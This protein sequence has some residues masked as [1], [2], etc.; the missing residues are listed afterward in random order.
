MI[1]TEHVYQLVEDIVE[2]VYK[3]VMEPSGTDCVIQ[4]TDK[5]VTW[6]EVQ[7]VVK[8]FQDKGFEATWYQNPSHVP[9]ILITW[10]V[11]QDVDKTNTMYATSIKMLIAYDNNDIDKFENILAEYLSCAYISA[12]K[13][14]CVIPIKYL[15]YICGKDSTFY[16]YKTFKNV[17]DKVSTRYHLKVQPNTFDKSGWDT[18]YISIQKIK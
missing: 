15:D 17:I 4:V 18:D 16:N 8:L 6:Q 14:V 2:V 13:S 3:N 10:G 5:D 11:P 1:W 9:V 7:E 12:R